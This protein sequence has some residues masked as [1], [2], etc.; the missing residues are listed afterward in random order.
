MRIPRRPW[1]PIVLIGVSAAAC[2]G[3][4]SHAP[5]EV[6]ARPPADVA[7]VR[8]AVT[9]QPDVYEA[10][11]VVRARTSATLVARIMA[12]VREV[13]VKPGDS[14]RAGQALVLLDDRDLAAN[15]RSA[16]SAGG[17]AE[18]A[19][20]AAASERDA[21]VAALALAKATFDRITALHAK[22]SATANEL[23]QATTGL[24][25][26]E[27][28]VAAATANAEAAA[29][30]VETARAAGEAAGVMASF[31][32]ITSPF[33]GIVTEK[34]VE[35]GNMASPGMPLVRVDDVRGFRLEVRL[36]ES[37]AAFVKTGDEVPVHID[38]PTGVRSVGGTLTEIARAVDSD[39]RA[40]LVKVALADTEG[41]RSGMY[42]RASIPGP[43]RKT[44]T[45]PESALVR[46]GQVN[47]V[48]V[49][50]QDRAR[51]RLVSAGPARDGRTEILA[52]V[53]DGDVV[54][55]A[56]PS[57]LVDGQRVRTAASSARPATEGGRE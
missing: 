47:A 16:R 11:G 30:S 6:D 23:D 39:A 14:V 17:A 32:V 37:R 52:G 41:L 8:A 3:G 33:D 7:T 48:F 54:V 42:G 34:L 21:A 49:V 43:A 15:A 35:P 38:G 51:M 31:A 4:G 50:D 46:R 56:P 45:V 53:S 25:A 20:Q 40:F 22:K 24:R 27:A 55:T 28:R 10:G 19:A 9:E 36:D 1:L 5:A 26:A 18:L 12:T 13:R 2:G 44:V 29:R 57:G